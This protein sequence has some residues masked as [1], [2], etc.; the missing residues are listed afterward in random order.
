MVQIRAASPDGYEILP[1]LFLDLRRYS[2]E[3]DPPQQDDF[4]RV[5]SASQEY[6]R[7]I[8]ARDD[9][10]IAFLAM[11]AEGTS[12]GYLV[13]GVYQPNPLTSAGAARTASIDELYVEDGY[14]GAGAGSA[15]MSAAEE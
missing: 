5:L 11:T 6:Q 14:R 1:P 3:R 8:L 4:D 15:L 12:A 9:D 13:A 10:A 7:E 2:R